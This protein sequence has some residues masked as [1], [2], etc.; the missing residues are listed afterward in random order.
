MKVVIRHAKLV[1]PEE[2]TPQ[3]VIW[4]SNIDLVIPRIH[5]PSVYFYNLKMGEGQDVFTFKVM[6][7]S[8]AK[9]LVPFYPMAGR[10]QKDSSGR[11]EINCN[12]EGVL[13]VEASVD[14][15]VSDFGDFAPT[16]ALKQLVPKVIYTEDISDCPLLVVQ[17]TFF[18]CGGVSLGV[19]MQH[20]VA[21]GMS[22]LHFINTWAKMARG[23][24]LEVNPFID[25]TLLRARQPPRPKF[26][27]LEYQPPPALLP[28]SNGIKAAQNGGLN[29]VYQNGN[30]QISNGRTKHHDGHHHPKNGFSNNQQQYLRVMHVNGNHF[31]HGDTNNSRVHIHE[32]SIDCHVCERDHCRRIPEQDLIHSSGE[33][34]KE[35]KKISNGHLYNNNHKGLQG[36][37]EISNKKNNH[38]GHDHC[39]DCY[40]ENKHTNGCLFDNHH[41]NFKQLQHDGS[42]P[43]GA[44]KYIHHNGYRRYAT[45]DDDVAT[46][47]ILHLTKQQVQELRAKAAGK[48][49][50]ETYSTYEAV[51]AHVWRCVSRARKLR[52]DQ[53]TKLYIAT[54]GRARLKPPLPEGYFGNVIFTATPIARAGELSEEGLSHG[55][56]KIRRALER[57]DDE[58]LRSALD[59]LELQPDLE[60]LVRGAH[61][62]KSPNLG[63]TSWTRLP[64]HD[65]D[66]GWGRP[67][68]MG[69]AGIPF[70]GLAYLLPGPSRDGGLSVS[71]AL[72][73]LHMPAF[74]DL[75]YQ[76]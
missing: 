7:S 20:H 66:F 73:S 67:V 8:L 9:A 54:D 70:E 71:L 50:G 14:A 11:I 37:E 1:K 34:I 27:H 64:I 55:A 75:F 49:T 23:G 46:P 25:R 39:H 41:N 5:T 35:I 4:N 18:R 43:N 16:M 76:F 30:F 47:A 32:Y 15:C 68:F 22:G 6:E 61:T 10:L 63:I 45:L 38:S 33:L 26:S 72:S 29:K 42:E 56:G 69:P 48:K 60:A 36:P 2:E 31:E 40:N 65:A 53:E 19:G 59:Y 52:S 24:D 74:L 57:M 28:E 51:S 21:D 3:E 62:F 58:Y 13:L 12:G 17:V 44:E